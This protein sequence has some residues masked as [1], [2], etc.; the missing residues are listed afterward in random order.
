MSCNLFTV[1]RFGPL[2]KKEYCNWQTFNTFTPYL[3]SAAFTSRGQN[4]L[5]GAALSEEMYIFQS[6]QLLPDCFPKK[7]P[8]FTL[9]LPMHRS[10]CFSSPWAAQ[11]A[12]T[13]LDGWKTV[14]FDFHSLVQLMF[15]IFVFSLLSFLSFNWWSCCFRFIWTTTS[16]GIWLF[17][18]RF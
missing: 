18:V 11:E 15:S 1:S 9:P 17:L 16:F 3:S 7:L 10:N 12:I 5:N 8:L 4:P 2:Q 13:L 14:A 6:Q